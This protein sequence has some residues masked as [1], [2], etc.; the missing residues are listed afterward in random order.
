[1]TSCGDP[2]DKGGETTQKTVATPTA[3]PSAGQVT[4]GTP[5][6]LS[7]ATSGASIYYTTNGTTPTTSSTLYSAA[8]PI[9]SALTIRAIAVKSGMKNSDMLTA[10]YT[11][12]ME[13]ATVITFHRNVPGMIGESERAV[14]GVSPS[15]QIQLRTNSFTRNG[16]VFTGWSNTQAGTALYTDSDTY[17]VGLISIDL[18]ATWR[19][20]KISFNTNG[21]GAITDI[22][23][24][25]NGSITKPSDPIKPADKCI[26]E[27]WYKEAGLTNKWN[28][29]T[30]IH[31]GLVSGGDIT[32]YAK[33][34]EHDSIIWAEYTTAPT[35][36]TNGI[37]IK[38]CTSCNDTFDTTRTAYATGTIGLEFTAI[39]GGIA[40]DVAT[41]TV[42]TGTV[43]I[44]AWYKP[45]QQADYLPVTEVA[46]SAFYNDQEQLTITDVFF[47]GNNMKKIGHGAFAEI[48]DLNIVLPDSLETID[49]SA[50]SATNIINIII[51]VSVTAINTQAFNEWTSSQTINIPFATLEDADTAWAYHE[52]WGYPWGW[53]ANSNAIIR[54][55]A[56]QQV[57]PE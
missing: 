25:T 9:D 39:D 31:T 22:D 7:T 47:I 48:N 29:D 30:D 42:T 57:W 23:A 17:N 41:G 40:Y 3:S 8:I 44:P 1:M 2:D 37:Q 27:G 15:S 52:D 38:G 55:N 49:S 34:N 16:Y 45:N 53:R 51:P 46:M 21:G 35:V 5:V 26:L 50:F 54:N 14:Q 33:W 4:L 43:H 13:G 32:L 12:T 24:N 11:V 56:G 28:F 20:A 10:A 6:T 19:L 36:T 18:Y